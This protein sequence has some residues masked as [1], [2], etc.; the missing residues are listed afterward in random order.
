[1]ENNNSTPPVIE[2]KA[3]HQLMVN[4][5]LYSLVL[6]EKE[7]ATLIEVLHRDLNN[8]I[9]REVSV[10]QTIEIL[11]A[12]TECH[13]YHPL[14]SGWER[15]GLIRPFNYIFESPDQPH[16]WQYVAPYSRELCDFFFPPKK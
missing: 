10:E 2:E 15:Y 7:I 11:H 12:T 5:A 14:G 1:M 6:N 4:G 3:Y 16:K 13:I 9:Q 8:Y